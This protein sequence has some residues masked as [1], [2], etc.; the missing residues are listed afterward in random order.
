MFILNITHVVFCFMGPLMYMQ[1]M[2]FAQRSIMDPGPTTT[3]T[4]G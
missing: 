1:F 4:M 2:F 3:V